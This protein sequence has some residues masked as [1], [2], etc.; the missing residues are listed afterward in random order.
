MSCASPRTLLPGV[1]CPPPTLPS[2]HQGGAT[3]LPA[4]PAGPPVLAR[5]ALLLARPWC[6]GCGGCWPLPAG[7]RPACPATSASYAG[8]AAPGD[9]DDKVPRAAAEGPAPAALAAG[10]ARRRLR[11]HPG[12]QR[13]SPVTAVQ[14]AH[15]RKAQL[16]TAAC[17]STHAA[18][19]LWCSGPSPPSCAGAGVSLLVTSSPSSSAA[20]IAAA[21]A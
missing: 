19:R 8:C 1:P 15:K 13:C 6:W 18:C 11:H 21:R 20:F 7:T 9:V 3:R 4:G 10:L 16:D 14:C 5:P 2:R 17:G 12:T